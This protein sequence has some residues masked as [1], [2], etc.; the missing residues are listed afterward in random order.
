LLVGDPASGKTQLLKLVSQLVPRGRYVSGK[1]VSAAGLTATVVRDEEFL[2][3]WTLEAGALVLCNKSVISIDEFD[4]IGKEDMINMHEA[5]STQTVSVAKATIFAT[6]PAK[7][8]VLAGSNPK[9]SRFD[10]MR[11]I[12]EQIDIPQTLLSRF[13]LKFVVRDVPDKEKDAKMIDH[14]IRMRTNGGEIKPPIELSLL[15]KYI[16]YARLNCKPKLG[17]E[18]A[19]I[20]KDFYVKLRAKYAAEEGFG[21]PLTLRQY[22]G[23]MRIAEASAKIRLAKTVGEGDAKRA[24]RLMHKS[25]K[26]LGLDPE[27]GKLDIDRVEGATTS[28]HRSKLRII[29]D[30]IDILAKKFGREIPYDDLI[31][32]ARD[33]GVEDAEKI[34]QDLRTRGIIFEPRHGYIQKVM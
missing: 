6:L 1:G 23:L 22:E 32:A 17:K 5:M 25:L 34:I 27:T 13:D 2:G 19:K 16:A 7:T 11:P 14:I 4:K 28:T 31:E 30:T 15:R 12:A 24:I 26:Q 33:E 10:P 21:V 9:F 8:A 18:A 3:G 20:L 29:M